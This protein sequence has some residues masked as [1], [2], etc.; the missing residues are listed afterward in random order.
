MKPL[1][2]SGAILTFK[3]F[4][5]YEINDAVFCSIDNYYIDAHLIIEKDPISNYYLIAD[6]HG[7]IN[8]WTNTIYGKVIKIEYKEE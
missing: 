6:N 4:L 5:T 8:G 1:I 3:S 2:Y 7:N